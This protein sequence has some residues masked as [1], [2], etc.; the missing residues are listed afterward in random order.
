[1]IIIIKKYIK[2][3][4][5]TWNVISAQSKQPD[6]QIFPFSPFFIYFFIHKHAEKNKQNKT[7][8]HTHTHTH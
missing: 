1:M 2:K 7:H 3:I 5:H 8:T 6:K 4:F